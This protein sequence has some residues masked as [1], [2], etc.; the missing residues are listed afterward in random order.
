MLFSPMPQGFFNKN[1]FFLSHKN[2]TMRCGRAQ[3]HS[4]SMAG[5]DDRSKQFLIG[6]SLFSKE[7]D[8]SSAYFDRSLSVD[9]PLF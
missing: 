2:Q 1:W 5:Q 8:W 3:N 6:H 4:R 9:R 7:I